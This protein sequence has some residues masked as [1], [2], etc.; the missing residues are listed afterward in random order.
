MELALILI[1]IQSRS[2]W[3]AN[4]CLVAN[5]PRVTTSL[6]LLPRTAAVSE[7]PLHLTLRFQKCIL[8]K[9]GMVNQDV[10]SH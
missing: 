9:Y 1:V 8:T 3:K 10:P 4:C 7:L 6:V 5:S 2:S